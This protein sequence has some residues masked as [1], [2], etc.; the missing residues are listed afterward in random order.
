MAFCAAF[1]LRR[2]LAT[3]AIAALPF[4]TLGAQ[5]SLPAAPLNYANSLQCSVTYTLLAGS[6]DQDDPES[7]ILREAAERWLMLATIRDGR[8]DDDATFAEYDRRLDA[9]IARVN[10]MEGEGLTVFL[11]GQVTS[12][13]GLQDQ[14]EAEFLSALEQ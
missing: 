4:A 14:H 2:A 6:L 9:I 13:Q 5:D 3:L 11:E 1:P 8:D 12:C 10:A 7:L